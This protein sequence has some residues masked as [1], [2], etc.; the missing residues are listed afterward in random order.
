[1]VSVSALP[2]EKLILILTDVS[3]AYKDQVVAHDINF[4]IEDGHPDHVDEV[5]GRGHGHW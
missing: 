5:G 4:T 1:M 3:V 2:S